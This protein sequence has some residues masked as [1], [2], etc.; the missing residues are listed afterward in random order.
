MGNILVFP[1]TFVY[2]INV[3]AFSEQMC[4]SIEFSILT[5]L[6]LLYCKLFFLLSTNCA[7]MA[8]FLEVVQHSTMYLIIF[9][10]SG[11]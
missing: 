4:N 2:F 5:F 8:A 10:L 3:Y 1:V 9:Q 11:I 6:Y 7:S